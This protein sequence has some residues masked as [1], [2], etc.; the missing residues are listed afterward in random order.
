MAPRANALQITDKVSKTFSILKDLASVGMRHERVRGVGNIKQTETMLVVSQ[1]QINLPPTKYQVYP[2]DMNGDVVGPVVLS[3]AEVQW[4]A[5]RAE[6][7]KI[8][9][10]EQLIDVGGKLE[11]GAPEPKRKKPRTDDTVGAS[12]LS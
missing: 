6:S 9:G 8:F 2:R 3:P 1:N 10:P 7:K 4:Q 12:V 11:V 5:T